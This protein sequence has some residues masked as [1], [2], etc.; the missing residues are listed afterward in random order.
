M[1]LD[2]S[3]LTFLISVMGVNTVHGLQDWEWGLIKKLEV[4]AFLRM[5]PHINVIY[6]AIMIS[7]LME[8]V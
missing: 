8:T 1:M 5:R 3:R 7:C 2:K 4:K 6:N